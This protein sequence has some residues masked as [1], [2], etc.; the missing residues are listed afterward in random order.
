MRIHI[1]TTRSLKAHWFT[2]PIR[3]FARHIADL[4]LQVKL[5]YG[6]GESLA[7]CDVLC[8]IGDYFNR[9]LGTDPAAMVDFISGYRSRGRYLVFFDVDDGTGPMRSGFDMLPYVDLYA[10]N[11]LLK[12]R[13][14][15]TESF[16]GPCIY[17]DYYHRHHAIDDDRPTAIRQPAHPDH[18]DKLAISWNLGLGDCTGA[19]QGLGRLGRG[20][21]IYWPLACY[22]VKPTSPSARRPVAV[23][24]RGR[25]DYGRPT[26]TFQRART[27]QLLAE[28]AKDGEYTTIAYEGKLPYRQ[29]RAEMRRAAIVVSPF[30]WGEINAG[31]DFECFVD[32]AAL[33]KPDMGHMETWPDY[34]ESGVTYIPHV[35]DFSDFQAKV[36][37]LLEHPGKREIIARVGQQRYLQSLSS[38]GGNAFANHFAALIK[39]A[40]EKS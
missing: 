40:V 29:Y 23:S 36:I 6:P 33:L 26:I 38:V 25:I 3:A 32:G 17:T 27:R 16:Y 2:F 12:D 4:G 11:Q 24:Y 22:Q 28:M 31:R 15:Y 39:K 35:W 37:D 10:K 21:A 1:L 13:A 7:A 19:Y 5:F 8:F 9:Q 20:L 30:G 18:L 34:F 14:R